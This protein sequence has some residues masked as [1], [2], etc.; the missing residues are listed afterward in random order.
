MGLP[1]MLRPLVTGFVVA[2]VLKPI[3][4]VLS[5]RLRRQ[6]LPV[7]YMPAIEMSEIGFVMEVRNS[8]ACAVR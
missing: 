5:R 3:C 7:R 2:D 8:L 1:Q 4:L 6:D